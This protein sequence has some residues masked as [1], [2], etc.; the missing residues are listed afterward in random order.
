MSKLFIFSISLILSIN[1]YPGEG[2]GGGGG[3]VPTMHLNNINDFREL[4]ME[5]DEFQREITLD[6]IDNLT[7]EE[8]DEIKY[9]ND[10]EEALKYL[11]TPELLESIQLENG[12]LLTR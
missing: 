12:Q 4:L 6:Q 3:R 8:D 1:I 2:G 10:S 5:S 9:I 7:F 11:M